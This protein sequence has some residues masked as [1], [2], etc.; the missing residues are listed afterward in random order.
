[1]GRCSYFDADGNNPSQRAAL[2]EADR[3]AKERRI[4]RESKQRTAQHV[5]ISTK[6]AQ[7]TESISSISARTLKSTSESDTIS[8]NSFDSLDYP[9]DHSQSPESAPPPLLNSTLAASNLNNSHD[10]G[11]PAVWITRTKPIDDPFEYD[12]P[13]HVD[14]R[15][16]DSGTE[17]EMA[18]RQFDVP[19]EISQRAPGPSRTDDVES[20]HLVYGRSGM[21]L[22]ED[23]EG[24]LLNTN[25]EEYFKEK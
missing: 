9:K 21:E 10:D 4:A 17:A 23:V 20:T 13:P 11:Q 6:E 19:R 5:S 22:E 2:R 25:D 14:L 24:S 8:T 7:L 12:I 16:M 15:T 18:E 3:K 1:M